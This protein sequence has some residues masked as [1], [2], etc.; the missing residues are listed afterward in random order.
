MGN[1]KSFPKLS[2]NMNLSQDDLDLLAKNGNYDYEISL[3]GRK[4]TEEELKDKKN[5][6]LGYYGI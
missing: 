5:I 3:V 6:N 4:L 1:V 2:E